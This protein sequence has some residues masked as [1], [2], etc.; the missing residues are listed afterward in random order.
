MDI[1]ITKHY[2]AGHI[3]NLHNVENVI[4]YLMI[5]IKTLYNV[6]IWEFLI[7]VINETIWGAVN[8]DYNT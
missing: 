4:Y 1:F 7:G 2:N 5:V 8:Y 3:F 6:L